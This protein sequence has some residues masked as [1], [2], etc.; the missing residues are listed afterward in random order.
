MSITA[1]YV[2][3]RLHGSYLN[4]YNIHKD[5]YSFPVIFSRS[6][7][8]VTK[9]IQVYTVANWGPWINNP[10]IVKA[11]SNENILHLL[12]TVFLTCGTLSFITVMSYECHGVS[13][14]RHIDSLLNKLLSATPKKPAKLHITDS[15][16]YSICNSSLCFDQV[17]LSVTQ[18]KKLRSILRSNM[19]I[20]L[21][22]DNNTWYQHDVEIMMPILISQ[23]MINHLQHWVLD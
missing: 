19:T 2:T 8:D 17:L 1:V 14:H 11:L 16:W 7:C 9:Q 3:W 23:D 6:P 5:I 20:P 4:A 22:R 12:E 13:N 18:T 21:S 10:Y 15:M